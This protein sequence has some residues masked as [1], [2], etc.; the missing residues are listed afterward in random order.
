LIY[1]RLLSQFEYDQVE[2]LKLQDQI[3][4]GYR[5]STP[6]QDAPSAIRAIALQ[7]LLEQK[8]QSRVNMTTTDSFISATETSL[9]GANDLLSDVKALALRSI[10]TTA[11]PEQREVLR[12]EI[13]NAVN[14]FIDIGNRSFRGRY[15][16][17][18]SETELHPFDQVGRFVAYNSNETELRNYIDIDLISE[19]NITGAEA[20]GALST[21][22]QGTVDLN[23]IVTANTRLADLRGGRGISLGSF[24]VSDGFT[25]KTIDISNAETV[26]DVMALLAE[27]PPNGRDLN[28]SLS[29]TGLV[30]D[31]DDAGGGNLT[32][33]ESPGGTTAAELGILHTT[34]VGVIPLTGGDLDPIVRLTTRLQDLLGTRAFVR[35]TFADNNNDLRIEAANNGPAFNNAQVQFVTGAVGDQAIAS[36]NS[37]S[38]ILTVQISPGVTRANTAIAA[39]NGTGVFTAELDSVDDANNDGSGV[40]NT[41]TFTTSGGSG[42]TLDQNSGIQIVNGDET[43]TVAF[44]GAE[45]IEDLLNVLNR[46]DLRIL[47]SINAEGT[48]INI[49]TRLSGADFMIGENG[50]TTA[51]QLG[52]RSLTS[53]T[54]LSDLNYSRGV[55]DADGD[56]L[57]IQ[58]RDGVVLNVD[59]TGADTVGDVL[60]RINSHPANVGNAVVAQL[61]A[62]GNGIELV[63]ANLAGT[64]NLTVFRGNSFAAWG[65]GLVPRNQDQAVAPTPG[66]GQPQVLTGTDVNPLEAVGV[67]NS[68]LRLDQALEVFDLVEIERAAALLDENFTDLTFVRAELGARARNLATLRDR[69]EREDIEVRSTLSKEIDTDVVKA[70][71]DLASRQANMQGTLQLIG[72][73]ADM[74]VLNYL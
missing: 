63:D 6:S 5:I 36:Y 17:G 60:T 49:R 42:E 70:I 29:G 39:I 45:T 23:P 19:S 18:G 26:G 47:A 25:S 27:N 24:I 54:F 21:E 57:L 2:L 9:V 16:F 14:Q 69:I 10:D 20:F 34:G 35:A 4:T 13:R 15:L 51:S 66:A 40:V 33:Q 46:P 67:F 43:F 28:V 41:A 1:A 72:R 31:I 12:S 56:D 32:I 59:I 64:Q 73:T 58:R 55:S 61:A 71:S 38:N 52:I 8:Q 62:V 74:T 44:P 37:G 11:T 53:Q 22:V 48:G 30:I 65:L 50:G 68:L 7:R 3:S